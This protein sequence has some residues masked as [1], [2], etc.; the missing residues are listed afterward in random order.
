MYWSEVAEI[1][2][3]FDELTKG[4]EFRDDE[5]RLEC[6]MDFFQ[7]FID[8]VENPVVRYL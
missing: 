4:H 8:G 2:A 3:M 6:E 7:Q 1:G 5:Q